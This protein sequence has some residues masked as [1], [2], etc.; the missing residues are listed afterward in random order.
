MGEGPGAREGVCQAATS[1][2]VACPFKSKDD[3]PRTPG[4]RNAPGLTSVR[5]CEIAPF[6]GVLRLKGIL[7]TNSRCCAQGGT[8][9]LQ[10]RPRGRYVRDRYL[11]RNDTPARKRW[12]TTRP[13][14]VAYL[15]T[16]ASHGFWDA[17]RVNWRSAGEVYERS[18]SVRHRSCR[19]PQPYT[20]SLADARAAA[21]SRRANVFIVIDTM[22]GKQMGFKGGVR[23]CG[24]LE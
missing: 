16:R 6:P 24:I 7:M 2:A 14:T 10:S 22:R 11:P 13:N 8:P 1:L 15:E 5:A 21:R 3:T 9:V 19:P 17:C 20:F 18:K 23:K 12:T 4:C